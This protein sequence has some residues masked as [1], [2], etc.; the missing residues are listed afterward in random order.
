ME[1]I[2]EKFD[3][4]LI[5]D[6]LMK[7]RSIIIHIRRND[8]LKIPVQL[9]HR[10]DDVQNN[11]RVIAHSVTPTM[12]LIRQ[13]DLDTDL[14]T[15]IEN[16]LV[17]AQDGI[18]QYKECIFCNLSFKNNDSKMCASCQAYAYSLLK[19]T[20]IICKESEFPTKFKCSTCVG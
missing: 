11:L 20:C 16:I 3:V 17:E 15:E 12:V 4:K 2:R 14:M 5:L 10:I 6:N 19:E 7:Q 1:L 18:N 9:I 8:F 13:F